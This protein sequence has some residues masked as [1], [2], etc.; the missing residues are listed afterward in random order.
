M[1]IDF[2]QA[3]GEKGERGKGGHKNLKFEIWD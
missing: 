1:A 2:S 3:G